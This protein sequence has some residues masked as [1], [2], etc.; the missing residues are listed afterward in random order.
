M[1]RQLARVDLAADFFSAMRPD[2]RGDFPSVGARGCFL[3]HLRVLKS[4]A[5][6]GR[7]MI[8]EDDLDF[9]SHF[10]ERWP[11]VLWILERE[12]WSIFYAGHYLGGRRGLVRLDP[13]DRVM[14]SHFMLINGPAI[15]FLARELEAILSRPSGHPLGGPMPVDGA[16]S[17]I[18]QQNQEL[19]TY[20][21]FPALGYQRPSRTDIADLRWF[22]R[23]L[24]LAP[25]V[26]LARKIKARAKAVTLPSRHH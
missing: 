10:R 25:A 16:Y 12:P 18:R 2:D 9:T 22:D 19:I 26:T 15:P 17:T 23:S 1:E 5:G 24:L 21:E 6:V 7:L 11:N 14:C 3:S 8:L 4:A 20:A 13:E